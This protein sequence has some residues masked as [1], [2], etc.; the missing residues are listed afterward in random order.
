MSSRTPRMR[1]RTDRLED[2]AAWALT[3]AGL[4]VVVAGCL[5]GFNVHEQAVA[6]AHSETVDRTPAVARLLADTPVLA[7]QYATTSPVMVPATWTDH[8]GSEHTGFVDAPQGLREGTTVP[9]WTDPTGASVSEPTSAED[10]LLGGVVAGALVLGAGLTALLALWAL[11]RWATMAANCARWEREWR[12][13]AQ[14][15]TRPG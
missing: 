9:I 2:W 7:S 10:A 6:R 12:E 3:A 14:V 5:I 15:W 13:V 11:V 1:R 8:T 4:L